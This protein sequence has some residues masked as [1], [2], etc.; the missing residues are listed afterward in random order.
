[1]LAIKRYCTNSGTIFQAF[2]QHVL[3]IK[4]NDVNM[5]HAFE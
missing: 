4:L 2:F 5:H 3:F 1:M